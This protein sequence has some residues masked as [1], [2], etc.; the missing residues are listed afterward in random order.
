MYVGV[1][2]FASDYINNKYKYDYRGLE[3]SDPTPTS[4]HVR[5]KLSLDVGG[6][7]KGASGHFQGFDA[8]VY[9][10]LGEDAHTDMPMGF[11]P[12]PDI[13]F[14]GSSSIMIDQTFN[15]SCVECLSRVAAA[16][17]SDKESQVLATGESTLKVGALPD[18]HIKLHKKL[19][20]EGASYISG[21]VFFFFFAGSNV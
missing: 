12:V 4:F 14:G 21:Y 17:A 7:F 11:F 9:S 8:T 16:A 2:R 20:V 18:A 5:Q 10:L 1:P 13:S 3:I 15:I 19:P 6:S